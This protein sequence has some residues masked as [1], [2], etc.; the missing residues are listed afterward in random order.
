MC[1]KNKLVRKNAVTYRPSKGAARSSIIPVYD[2]FKIFRRPFLK[3]G[4]ARA[5]LLSLFNLNLFLFPVRVA[6]AVAVAVAVVAH[7]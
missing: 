2:S 6:V 5:K 3:K 1:L 4:D 7:A